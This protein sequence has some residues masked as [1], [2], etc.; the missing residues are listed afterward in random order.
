MQNMSD[1][2]I[3]SKG[4]TKS[5]PMGNSRL[6]VLKG[7]DF[8][9]QKGE[10]VCIVGSSGAGKSTLLHILGT[11]DQPTLGKVYFK[12]QDLTRKG[13]AAIAKFR[14]DSM[15]FVFQFHHLLQEFRAIENVMMPCRLAGMSPKESRKLAQELIDQMGLSS[16]AEHFPSEMSGGEQQRLAI[17]R[18][19]VRKP[20]VLF[21]DEPT[22]EPT[23]NLDTENAA[24]IQELFFDLKNRMNL[25]LITVTHDT[26]FAARFPRV[27]KM[28]DGRWA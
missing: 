6:E 11:L 24:K 8:K 4:V 2:I 5:Y 26:S 16:R 27:L 28:R 22:D 15:G 3:E 20:E 1:P 12:G 10:A 18:A 25:T 21:A 9:V 23:G 13:E 7:V 14:G 17:A 19:L